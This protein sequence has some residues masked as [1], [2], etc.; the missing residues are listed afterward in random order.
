M[1]LRA[2]WIWGPETFLPAVEPAPTCEPGLSFL[3]KVPP[4]KGVSVLH[5]AV[6]ASCLCSSPELCTYFFLLNVP[7]Q[8]PSCRLQQVSMSLL[9]YL[10]PAL[11]DTY[12]R[13]LEALEAASGAGVIHSPPPSGQDI[14]VSNLSEPSLRSCFIHGST[15]EMSPKWLCFP[16]YV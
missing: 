12:A 4:V 6:L 15:Y 3:S 9:L 5:N 8:S 2:Y 13:G 14:S 7:P 16:S 11:S 1:E 10:H